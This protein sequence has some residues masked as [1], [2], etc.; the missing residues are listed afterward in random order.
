MTGSRRLARRLVSGLLF[1][2]MVWFVGRYFYDNLDAALAYEG[3]WHGGWLLLATVVLLLVYVV[4]ALTWRAILLRTGAQ[5][6][7]VTAVYIYFFGLLAAYIPGRVWGPMG[8]ISSASDK[9]VPPHRSLITTVFTTGISLAAAAVV[10]IFTIREFQSQWLWLRA[11]TILLIMAAIL[12]PAQIAAVINW[13][14]VRLGRPSI[15]PIFRKL[16]MLLILFVYLA[17]WILYGLALYFFAQAIG[18]ADEGLMNMI[19]A[20]AAA[21]LAGYVAFFTPA[22]LGVREVVLTEALQLTREGG[23]MIWLSLL[24]RIW[25]FGTQ[26]CGFSGLLLVGWW[27][28]HVSDAKLFSGVMK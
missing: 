10:S 22:G 4:Q 17:S 16:D 13:G 6:G 5:L 2:G 3:E 24:S 19:G 9:G 1:V 8:M 21:Y 25:L 15:R 26:L 28:Q 11:L 27:Q 23:P 20:N 14:L 7:R 18:I 12:F